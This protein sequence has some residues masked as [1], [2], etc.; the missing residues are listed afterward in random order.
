MKHRIILSIGLAVAAIAVGLLAASSPALADRYTRAQLDAKLEN[1]INTAINW[2]SNLTDIDSCKSVTNS[3]RLNGASIATLRNNYINTSYNGRSTASYRSST[4]LSKLNFPN[5]TNP[6]TVAYGATT[7]DLQI[8]NVSFLCGTLVAPDVGTSCSG[9]STASMYDDARW[10]YTTNPDQSPNPLGNSCLRPARTGTH[11]R[12]E[13]VTVTSTGSFG[14]TTNV[15]P[16][17]QLATVRDNLSRYW[18]SAPVGFRYTF[19]APVTTSGTVK[20]TLRVKRIQ[21][22]NTGDDRCVSGGNSITV[23]SPTDYARCDTTTDSVAL[24]IQPAASYNLHPDAV[25]SVSS[26]GNG[27]S[28]NIDGGVRNNGGTASTTTNW[29][30]TRMYFAAGVTPPATAPADSNNAACAAYGGY[31]AGSCQTIAQGTRGFGLGTTAVGTNTPDTADLARGAQV[32]YTASVNT[33]TPSATPLW[34][35]SALRCVIIGKKPKVQV[36]GGDARVR[37]LIN[38]STSQI[39]GRLFGSWGEYGVMSVGT[40][41]GMASGSGLNGGG[42]PAA[43]ALWNK[44]TF[45]NINNSGTPSF[46]S[47][48]LPPVK[49]LGAQFGTGGGAPSSN[50]GSLAS[51]N[52]QV[53]GAGTFTINTSDIGQQA[54]KGKKIIIRVPNGTVRIAGNITYKGS[55]ASDTFTNV[56]QLPQVIII[57][58]KIDIMNSV[59]RVDAWLLTARTNAAPAAPNDAINTCG[60]VAPTGAITLS[61]CTNVLTINGPVVTS[62]LYLRRTAGSGATAATAGDPAEVFNLRADTFLWARN[63]AAQNGKAQTVYSV[64]LP[65]RF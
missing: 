14:G 5:T 53:N 9:L 65:P 52:Y 7:I 19:N 27:E 21:S 44:L 33:P 34:R 48:T 15:V 49:D 46:G 4:W 62:H 10:V 57:A 12:I 47:F 8:N 6:V 30:M 60:D 55:G 58:N 3:A 13:G 50:L 31:A 38:T 41:T 45:A 36:W 20:L 17:S 24:Q 61:Q 37:G 2:D 11:T 29:R 16:G 43:P 56:D 28:F 59:G 42:D 40:N 63:Q 64:E 18:F 23:S 1:G 39:N 26:V 32:C 51:G 35:H 54:G 25:P 22:Y